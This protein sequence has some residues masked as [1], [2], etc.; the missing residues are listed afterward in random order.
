MSRGDILAGGGGARRQRAVCQPAQAIDHHACHDRAVESVQC[1]MRVLR[2]SVSESA[3][4]GNLDRS[5]IGD[6]RRRQAQRCEA[7]RFYPCGRR[8]ARQSSP[9]RDDPRRKAGAETSIG[10]GDHKRDSVDRRSIQIARRGWGGYSG[11]FDVLSR[12]RR[13]SADLRKRRL[14]EGGRQHRG[15]SGHFQSLIRAGSSSRFGR[16]ERIGA[17]IPCS[18]PRGR[19]VGR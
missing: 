17:I 7:S 9:G 6:H 15:Y 10:L 8:T 1:E 12:R 13:I 19:K 3:A 14:G 11:H 5:R 4:S 18:A 2:I 16:R